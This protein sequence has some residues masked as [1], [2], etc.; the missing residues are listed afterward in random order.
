MHDA[1]PPP[2]TK[3]N[4]RATQRQATSDVAWEFDPAIVTDDDPLLAFEPVPHLRPRRNS[5]TPELQRAFIAHLAA[6]GIVTSAAAHI[7]KSMEAIYKLRQRP[8][9]EE[10]CDAWDEALRWG[11]LRLED[12]AIERALAEGF[13]NPRANSMLAW[14]LNYRGF[15]RVE[16]RDVVPGH[17]LYE[18]IKERV[19]REE[20][21]K[22]KRKPKP[23]A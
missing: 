12:C 6:T 11:V 14:V 4:K 17:W 19:L 8:G 20:R 1:S 23:T 13:S 10:F 3:R 7:G 22:R 16:A 9:A 21:E 2:P 18:Q 5:I 15:M